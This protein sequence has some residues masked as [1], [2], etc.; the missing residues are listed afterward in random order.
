MG[1]W[2]RR[3]QAY[4]LVVYDTGACVLRWLERRIGRARMTAFLRL[5][6]S[7]HRH[8]VVT[9]PELLAALAEAVPGVDLKRFMHLAHISG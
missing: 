8:G 4:Q 6:V 7:R 1:F 2:A 3:D 5:V 9:E